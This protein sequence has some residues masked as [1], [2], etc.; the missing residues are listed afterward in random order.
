MMRYTVVSVL[1]S[2]LLLAGCTGATFNGSRTGNNSQLVMEYSVFNTTDSQAL[3]L[4]QGDRLAV[5]I[6]HEHGTLSLSVAKE[7]E[8]PLYQNLDAKTCTF[9][10]AIPES[11]TY[12]VTATGEQAKG[13]LSVVRVVK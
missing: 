12:W 5:V 6:V 13:S 11:G 10:L 7:G 2:A 8:E 4:E 3:K 9:D 1:L